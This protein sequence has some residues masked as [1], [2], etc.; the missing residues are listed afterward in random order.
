MPFAH[1]VQAFSHYLLTPFNE[2][3]STLVVIF[4]HWDDD[5][6][7]VTATLNKRFLRTPMVYIT[8][9]VGRQEI[10]LSTVLI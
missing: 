4:G 7:I 2:P 3:Y 8:I 10:Y 6:C 5:E 1:P 9:P